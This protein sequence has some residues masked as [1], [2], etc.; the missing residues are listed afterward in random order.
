MDGFCR[1]SKRRQIMGIWQGRSQR[2][3]TGGR[4]RLVTKKRKAEIGG[5]SL[6]TFIGD[7]KSIKV[8]VRGGKKKVKLLRTHWANVADQNTNECKKVRVLSVLE[9]PANIHYVRRNIITKGAVIETEDGGKARVTSRP[10]QDGIVNAI[11]IE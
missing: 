8:R 7:D 2:K 4:R 11:K 1:K 3:A 5:D 10:T 9:N 6:H